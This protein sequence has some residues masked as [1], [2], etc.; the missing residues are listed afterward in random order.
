MTALMIAADSGDTQQIIALGTSLSDVN[1]ADE[2]GWTAIM[3]A[4]DSGHVDCIHA[5]ADLQAGAQPH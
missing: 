3:Y 2:D 4:A 1:A 5:L